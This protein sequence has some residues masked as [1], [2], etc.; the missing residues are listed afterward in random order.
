MR[1]RTALTLAVP[2]ALALTLAGCGGDDTGTA[3]A[4]SSAISSSATSA[5]P[6]LSANDVDVLT[7][8]TAGQTWAA[9]V[10]EA[11]I[12][13]PGRLE[14]TTA[15]VDPRGGSTGTLEAQQ[16][17]QVCQGALAYMQQQG[18]SDPYVKVNESNGTTFA[19]RERGAAGCAEV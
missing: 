7:D 1:T 15:I 11:T 9:L 16:A 6:D 8:L 4:P 19:L 17:L 5:V 12:T 14:V 10:S 2:A 18:Q 13:E 3:A